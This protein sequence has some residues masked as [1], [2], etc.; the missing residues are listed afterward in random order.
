MLKHFT[1]DVLDY[2]G[3]AKLYFTKLNSEFKSILDNNP[4]DLSTH[5]Q[6]ADYFI[7]FQIGKI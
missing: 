7:T 2:G 4:F 6:M 3:I 1:E 5:Q